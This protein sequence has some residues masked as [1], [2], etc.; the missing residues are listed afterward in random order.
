MR[1][2]VLG[3]G[4]I[5]SAFDYNKITREQFDVIKDSITKLYVLLQPY[6]VIINT[7]GI[8]DTIWTEKQEN[9]KTTLL[10][11]SYFVGHLS[12]FCE[13]YD[14][15]LIHISTGD[16]YGNN[17]NWSQNTEDSNNLDYNTNYRLSKGLAEKLCNP[18]DTILRIRLPFDNRKHPKNLLYKSRNFTK[19]Y[20]FQNCYTYVP[21]LV[22]YIKSFII[23]NDLRGIYNI[24]QNETASLLYL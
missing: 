2:V 11:N 1:I 23:P 10:V 3:N 18:N 12:E 9:L 6:D 19:F 4:Y 7:I 21:D 20:Q 16:L 13:K 17:F 8:T 22:S 15:K 14:K 5:G 24:C